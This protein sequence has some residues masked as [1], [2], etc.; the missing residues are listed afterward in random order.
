MTISKT[1]VL[2]TTRLITLKLTLSHQCEIKNYQ[3]T[4][5]L[6]VDGSCLVGV[7]ET[8]RGAERDLAD[9]L[10]KRLNG[11]NGNKEKA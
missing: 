3:E 4:H 11:N 8:I 6:K 9:K 1:P 2:K 7:G 10:S 5:S